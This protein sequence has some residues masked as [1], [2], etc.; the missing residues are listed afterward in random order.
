MARRCLS[1]KSQMIYPFN[2]ILKFHGEVKNHKFIPDQHEAFC[3]S[4]VQHEGK[5]ITVTVGRQR[6][7]RSI[8]QNSYLHLIIKMLGDHLG[9]ELEEMK[10]IIKWVF[11]V[12]HTSELSTVED[13]ELC[14]QIRR[15]AIKEFD[16]YIPNPNE[17]EL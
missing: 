3:N 5:R 9:Y 6:K 10:G 17:V 2:M 13:E 14:E 7:Q 11:K 15:W 4:F 1:K 12:K 16:F 8:P